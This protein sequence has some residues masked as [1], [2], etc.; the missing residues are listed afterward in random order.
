MTTNKFIENNKNFLQ[1]CCIVLRI[2]KWF[3]LFV[4]CIFALYILMKLITGQSISTYL[5]VF[6]KPQILMFLLGMVLLG[7]WQF[8][9]YLIE[10]DYKPGRLLLNGD[11]ILYSYSVILIFDAVWTYIHAIIH[12]VRL[13]S[14]TIFSFKVLMY[15]MF[16]F[17]PTLLVGV[18][19]ASVLVGLGLLFK[20][21]MAALEKPTGT[22]GEK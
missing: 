21:A 3:L 15:M 2:I 5:W 10:P 9:R 13:N 16:A 18:A 14:Q 17:L 1:T 8:I 12:N 4:P 6:A 7:A 19:C 20:R 11:K 22:A